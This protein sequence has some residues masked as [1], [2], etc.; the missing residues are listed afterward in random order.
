MVAD[1]VHNQLGIRDLSLV[2]RSTN[3]SNSFVFNNIDSFEVFNL[4]NGLGDKPSSGIDN[5]SIKILKKINYF[6]CK[7]LA[8]I[9]N[10]CVL[11]GVFPDLLKT[12]LVIPIYKKGDP[13]I[14]NNYRPVSILSTFSKLLERLVYN[15][16][17]QFL[18]KYDL[19]IDEQHGFRSH[20]STETAMCQ[21]FDYVYKALDTGLKAIGLFFDLSKA[22]DCLDP[23][24]VT[25]KLWASEADS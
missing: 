16:M 15:R 13:T 22:F 24:I 14:I 3:N 18:Y 19:L 7:P 4:I 21:F 2:T 9:F 12:A 11:E 23:E 10:R 1:T 25:M 6:I 17:T 8:F 20:R 5:V